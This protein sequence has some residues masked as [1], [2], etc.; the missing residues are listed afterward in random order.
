MDTQI[1]VQGPRAGRVTMPMP[2]KPGAPGRFTP[3]TTR[4]S[5]RSIF[6][7]NASTATAR[8]GMVSSG[9]PPMA[10]GRL[11]YRIVQCRVIL[12]ARWVSAMRLIGMAVTTIAKSGCLSK[13]FSFAARLDIGL[14]RDG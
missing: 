3:E 9:L 10:A 5:G 4:I 13:N 14:Q 8:H 12:Y 6:R 7:E 1:E 11:I 2:A